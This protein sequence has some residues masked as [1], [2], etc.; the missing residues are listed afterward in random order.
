[1]NLKCLLSGV[2]VNL[3]QT[4]TQISYMC[5]VQPDGSLPDE[6]TGKKARHALQIYCKWVE[7]SLNGV[8]SK[9]EDI[10]MTRQLVY[11]E[12]GRI[13]DIIKSKKRLEVWVM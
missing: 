10:K 6:L 11:E 2:H 4:P 7:G 5:I 3:R 12:I 13:Q 8:H 9:F 1:M